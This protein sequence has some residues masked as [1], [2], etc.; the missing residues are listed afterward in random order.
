MRKPMLPVAGLI[1]HMQAKNITFNVMSV[2]AAQ[3]YLDKNNN[4]FKLTSYRKNYPKY[5]SGNR[6][7]QYICLDFAYLIELARI[8]VQLRKVILGMCLDIEHF[9]KVKLIK[10]IEDDPNQDGYTIVA[11][12]LK[13][14]EG[15]YAFKQIGQKLNNPYCGD[16]IRA[17]QTSMPVWAFVEVISFGSLLKF[18]KYVS[19]NTTWHMPVDEISLDKVR[20]IRNAAAHNNCIIND[21]NAKPNAKSP[22]WHIT[23]F[24]TRCGLN[25]NT[26]EKKMSNPRF[27]QMM[28]MLYVFDKVV[29]SENSRNQ[30]LCI[31]KQLV[32]VR[33]LEHKEYFAKNDMITSTYNAFR[34]V[35]N[36]IS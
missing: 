15:Q 30:S 7:G 13:T 20:Q 34:E 33:M 2:D 9:L 35:V 12:F 14:D 36:A 24:V 19:E 1:E 23:E 27:A 8:D 16:L 26:R 18:A 31:L 11:D 6:S 5:N 25:K 32:N 10:G 22:P 3:N 4:Y 28:H 21:L 29:Q 17:Y